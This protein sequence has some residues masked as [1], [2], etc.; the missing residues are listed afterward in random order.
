MIGIYI[1]FK[2]ELQDFEVSEIESL[3]YEVEKDPTTRDDYINPTIE[4][5][6]D[7]DCDYTEEE[8]HE[9]AQS[10]IEELSAIGIN[11]FI[12]K[13]WLKKMRNKEY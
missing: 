12:V 7:G 10:I 5:S 3:G 9:E 8:A 13:D 4:Y 1:H 2:N 11:A 6:V